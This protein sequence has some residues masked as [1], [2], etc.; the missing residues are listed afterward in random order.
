MKFYLAVNCPLNRSWNQLY[1]SA[2]VWEIK[3]NIKPCLMSLIFHLSKLIWGKALQ[4]I[5][6]LLSMSS[7]IALGEIVVIPSMLLH[8]TLLN[9]TFRSSCNWSD[10][11][12]Y[13]LDQWF[14]NYFLLVLV[15]KAPASSYNPRVEDTLRPKISRPNL[16]LKHVK[17][18]NRLL[19]I[20]M[21]KICADRVRL[22]TL[23]IP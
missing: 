19:P 16:V 10:E 14:L 13:K 1:V 22:R 23:G 9:V 15:L 18:K 7:S 3:Q 21:L 12:K 17:T 4:G 8:R 5:L 11:R 2:D 6:S 20:F